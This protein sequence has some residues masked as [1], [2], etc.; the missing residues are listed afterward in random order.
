MYVHVVHNNCVL[1]FALKLANYLRKIGKR[2]LTLFYSNYSNLY[3]NNQLFAYSN[4]YYYSAEYE[5]EQIIRYSSSIYGLPQQQTT[6][7]DQKD[8]LGGPTKVK[9]TYIFVCKI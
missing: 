1:L 9:P 3:S 8:L 5:Y 2:N 6:V 7:A 4:R